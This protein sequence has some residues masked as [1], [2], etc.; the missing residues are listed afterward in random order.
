MLL[1]MPM[2]CVALGFQ[3]CVTFFLVLVYV[4][5]SVK[6]DHFEIFFLIDLLVLGNIIDL[7]L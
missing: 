2:Q 4:T 5:G 7:K 1:L 6:W 3:E